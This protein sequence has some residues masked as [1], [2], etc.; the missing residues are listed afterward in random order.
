M[1]YCV[2]VKASLTPLLTGKAQ[3]NPSA[4]FQGI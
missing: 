1:I 4:K 2:P 3:G